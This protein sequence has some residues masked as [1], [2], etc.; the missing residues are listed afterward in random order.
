MQGARSYYAC[1]M[2]N[3]QGIDS[4][5]KQARVR[6]DRLE[7]AVAHAA[8]QAGAVL[9]DT[10]PEYQRREHGD[11]PGALIIDRNVLEWRLDPASGS[12]LSIADSYDL[13]I[14]VLCQQGYSSSLAAASLQE[15]GLWRAT[16]VI[17]GFEAWREAGLP[18]I[19]GSYD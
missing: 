8:T 16:D 13:Q 5:L 14:I 3:P 18:V 1:A 6:L 10:R 9:V 4:V 17:G 19:P 7:P 12:R 15:I 11:V 2:G